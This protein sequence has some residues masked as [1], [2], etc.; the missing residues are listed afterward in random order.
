MAISSED[1]HWEWSGDPEAGH[2][3]ARRAAEVTFEV[4]AASGLSPY[5]G[6]LST[7]G[8]CFA[9]RCREDEH[10]LDRLQQSSAQAV[11][12][13]RDDIGCGGRPVETSLAAGWLDLT[14]WRF[15]AVLGTR[16]SS[17]PTTAF[18]AGLRIREDPAQE[19][20]PLNRLLAQTATQQVPFS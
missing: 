17:A 8:C 3:W 5:C 12:R 15:R 2:S 1:A 6:L 7:V 18:S 19:W 13:P 4:D 14:S 20:G 11:E 16:A 10:R 9:W